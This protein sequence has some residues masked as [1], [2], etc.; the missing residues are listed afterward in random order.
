MGF[1]EKE[2]EELSG[3]FLCALEGTMGEQ[4]AA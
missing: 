1:E 4:S 2:R 3:F